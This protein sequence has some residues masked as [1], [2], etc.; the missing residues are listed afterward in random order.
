VVVRRADGGATTLLVRPDGYV[1]AAR[2]Q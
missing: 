1:A 2:G